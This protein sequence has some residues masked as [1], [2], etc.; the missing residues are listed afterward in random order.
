MSR[1]FQ[2]L[3]SWAGWC[4]RKDTQTGS[5]GGSASTQDN[6]SSGINGPMQKR[7]TLFR[8]LTW[9]MVWL[10]YLVPLIAL[11]YLPDQIPVH[12][13]LFGVAD[14]FEGKFPGVFW[15]PVVVTLTTLFL[16]VLPRIEKLRSGLEK[17]KDIYQIVIFSVVAL[18]VAME[19]I[20]TLTAL[21][22]GIRIEVVLPMLFGLLFIVLGSFMPYIKRNPVMGIRLPWTLSDDEVWRRSH[23]RGGPAFVIAGAIMVVFSPIAGLWA[24]LLMLILV[25]GVSVWV[26][27]DSYKLSRLQVM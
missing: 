22:T 24:I 20:T 3:N 13:N 10:S 4:P 8:Y 21:G 11:R 14:R 23:E 1:I 5:A 16:S 25:I 6:P 26:V 27:I 17:S 2:M 7:V 12:W 18:L 15:Y 9:F 19:V